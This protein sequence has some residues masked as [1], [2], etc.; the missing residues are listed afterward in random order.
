MER[1]VGQL[2]VDAVRSDANARVWMKTLGSL[3]GRTGKLT[4]EVRYSKNV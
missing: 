3:Y 2:G 1:I 4:N